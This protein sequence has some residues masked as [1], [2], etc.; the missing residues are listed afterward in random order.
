MGALQVMQEVGKQWQSMSEVDRNYF[1]E[2][3]DHDKVRYLNDQ[4][5]YYDEV[6]K[7]GQQNGTIKTKD[8][9]VL[10]AHTQHDPAQTKGK[11]K[12]QA[13]KADPEVITPLLDKR[14]SESQVPQEA[15][16]KR[17]KSEEKKEEPAKPPSVLI[18]AAT[19]VAQQT[20]QAASPNVRK[21]ITAYAF[22]S[23]QLREIVRLRY[24]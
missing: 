22:F 19:T 5:A 8:G 11:A 21:P 3:A 16:I 6:Q 1:K 17:V 13:A 18:Q 2:K 7:I 4:R 9:V 20:Q 24:S 10:V 14:K 15:P 23:K 12:K